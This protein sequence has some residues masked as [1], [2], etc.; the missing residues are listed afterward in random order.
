VDRL[1]AVIAEN[2]AKSRTAAEALLSRSS[3]AELQ[4]VASERAARLAPAGAPRPIAT[5]LPPAAA[6]A[7]R[8]RVRNPKV[9]GAPPPLPYAPNVGEWRHRVRLAAAHHVFGAPLLGNID[10]VAGILANVTERERTGHARV[11]HRAMAK[12][13]VAGEDRTGR[14]C[15]VSTVRRVIRWMQGRGL[16]YVINVLARVKGKLVRTANLYLI[17]P[18]GR[19]AGSVTL[20][21]PPAA[22]GST[23]EVTASSIGEHSTGS[24]WAISAS[25]GAKSAGVTTTAT[26]SAETDARARAE[27]TATGRDATTEHGADAS[28]TPGQAKAWATASAWPRTGALARFGELF[29]LVPVPPSPAPS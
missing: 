18:I 26:G 24:A 20:R 4:A 6:V 13:G 22:D 21:F 8:Q 17:P 25:D 15:S 14:N 5:T 11:T 9:W 28:S 27:S 29:G 2:R 12:Y 16:L 7:A 10:R 23:A 3:I 1:A 19:D